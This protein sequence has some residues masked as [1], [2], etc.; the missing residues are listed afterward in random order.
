MRAGVVLRSISWWRE[1]RVALGADEGR[2][3]CGEPARAEVVLMPMSE[4]AAPE[5]KGRRVRAFM[6]LR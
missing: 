3:A 6:F 4:T 2:A 1:V 5:M